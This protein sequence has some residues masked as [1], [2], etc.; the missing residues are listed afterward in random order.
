M[1]WAHKQ[2]TR[3][4]MHPVGSSAGPAQDAHAHNVRTRY[5]G[6]DG[7][8]PPWMEPSV[9]GGRNVQI[10]QRLLV[11]YCF[12]ALTTQLRLTNKQPKFGELAQVILI[13]KSRAIC[14]SKKRRKLSV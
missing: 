13:L 6:I 2:L 11:S 5:V 4:V 3:P 1:L 12:C 8:S 7:Q 14:T 9:L 10:D